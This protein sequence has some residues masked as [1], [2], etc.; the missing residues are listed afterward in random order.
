MTTTSATINHTPL[1]TSIPT[2]AFQEWL[3]IPE[4]GALDFVRC[5]DPEPHI[6]AFWVENTRPD[7]RLFAQGRPTK[8]V[9]S[10]LKH[11]AGSALVQQGGSKVLVA[12]T[13]QIGQPSPERP[14]EGEVNVVV[15]GSG[16][17]RFW[18]R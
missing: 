17:R 11:S 14:H 13:I 8:V 6:K 9:E 16:G 1:P 10:M 18:L 2:T 4:G 12:M 5:L 7:G 15:S 3:D